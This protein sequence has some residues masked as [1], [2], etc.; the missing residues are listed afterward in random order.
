MGKTKHLVDELIAKRSKGI[1]AL[2]INT[3]MK[4][5]M[6]GIDSKKINEETPDDEKV[7]Q[8]IYDLALEF[9][10]KLD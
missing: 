7:L 2:A 6:K 1:E 5:L 8:K 3:R 9:N 10:I 4:L